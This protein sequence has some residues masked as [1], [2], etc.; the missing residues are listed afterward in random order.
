MERIP[1]LALLTLHESVA[2]GTVT[3]LARALP[4]RRRERRNPCDARASREQFVGNWVASVHVGGIYVTARYPADGYGVMRRENDMRTIGLRAVLGLALLAATGCGSSQSEADKAK[5]QACSARSDIKA[6]ISKL[7]GLPLSTSS[8]ATA[9]TAL[10]QIET[11]LK[12]ISSA[13]P[14]VTGSVKTQLKTANATFK[15]QVD[16]ALHSIT[17]AQSLSIAVTAVKSAGTT[18][19]TSYQQTFANVQC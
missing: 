9:K 1:P 12:T 18:L 17:S 2:G 3:N 19:Q 15:T 6:Q 7:K 11:D 4:R 10:Q 14:T 8:V 13:V 5:S 16:Q